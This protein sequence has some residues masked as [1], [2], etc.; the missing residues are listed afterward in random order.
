VNSIK[1]KVGV[2]GPNKN[3]IIKKRC[4]NFDTTP[5]LLCYFLGHVL[6]QILLSNIGLSS[7][8]TNFDKFTINTDWTTNFSTRTSEGENAIIFMST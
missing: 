4:G 6:R 2:R 8:Q 5:W 1:E 3:E 7:E